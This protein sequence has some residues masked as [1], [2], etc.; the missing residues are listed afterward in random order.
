M[1]SSLGRAV[2][3]VATP[4]GQGVTLRDLPVVSL[5]AVSLRL[6]TRAED[7]GDRAARVVPGVL[8]VP[9]VLAAVGLRI[10][11]GDKAVQANT[12]PRSVLRRSFLLV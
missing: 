4:V 7:P 8:G 2:A 3:V 6:A 10:G 5:L 1:R 11:T 9:V 12:I